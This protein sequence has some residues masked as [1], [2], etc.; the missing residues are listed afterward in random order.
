VPQAPQLFESVAVFVQAVPHWVCPELQ[1]ELHWLLLQT[2]ADDG[3]TFPQLPQLFA[4]DVTHDEP[5]SIPDE[6]VHFPAWQLCPDEQTVPQAP[7]F[8][9]SVWTSRQVP[10]HSSWPELQVVLAG[11][12]QPEPNRPTPRVA[13]KAKRQALR[14][15]IFQTP[16]GGFGATTS[17]GGRSATGPHC[18]PKNRG[19]GGG[20]NAVAIVHTPP[21]NPNQFSTSV[22]GGFADIPGSRRHSL[23]RPI[24]RD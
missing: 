19:D 13:T 4:S 22:G 3:Q 9:L 5:H 24:Q 21:K 20:R 2:G 8:R 1:L 11:L 16:Y 17:A 18:V 14:A 12:A 15:S 6:Q 23:L 7:Q 10:P